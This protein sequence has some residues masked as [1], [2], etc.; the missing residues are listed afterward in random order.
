VLDPD[1]VCQQARLSLL[2]AAPV[3]VRA[4]QA[5]QALVGSRIDGAAIAAAADAAVA[6]LEPTGDIHGSTKYRIK[7]LRTMAS[8]AI[9][10]AL[11]H[12]RE[13]A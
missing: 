7:L 11:L 6:G 1:G 10:K 4:A 3:P 13:A 9:A 8:R 12:G 2:A 5:E